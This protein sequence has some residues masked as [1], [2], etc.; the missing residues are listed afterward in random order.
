M[1]TEQI[2]VSAS[3][4]LRSHW[5]TI[6]WPQCQKN[7]Q[8]LQ[9]RIVQ[10]TK[11]ERWNKV[12]ALQHLLTRSF[13]AKSLAVKR[14]T[15]NKGKWTPGVDGQI[16]QTSTQKSQAIV[17]L[18]QRGYRPQPLRRVH[19]LKPNGKKRPLGIPT[20]KDRAMQA[21]YLMGLE[22]VAETTA[23]NHSYGFR[24]Y[25]S[26]A[27]AISQVFKTL[28][29]WGRRPEWILEGDI[30]SC[31]DA[32]SH[33]WLMDAIPIER[34]ILK[35]WLK[36]GFM[37]KQKLY[38]TK[39]GTPQGSIISPVLA[40]MALDG[41]ES[42]LYQQFGKKGTK[43]RKQSGVHLIRYAD[44]FV[45][46]GKTKEILEEQVR[47]VIETF[48]KQRGLTLSAEKTTITHIEQGFDFLGQNIRKY[49][50]KLI[51]KP[52]AK[53]IHRLLKRVKDVIGKNQ[54]ATQETVIKL[55]NPQIRGWAYYHRHVCARK[56]YEKVD[57]EIFSSL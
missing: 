28:C 6:N 3:F 49:K 22:P 19:I 37:E 54:A 56:S 2:S 8:R 30:K 34:N 39:T 21:L 51:I 52:S 4:D 17:S 47:A 27:D 55:L 42:V 15:E 40:N 10:A 9:A 11:R 48:L 35:K 45:I 12:K 26:G 14:V 7:V 50:S 33:E 1:V 23:D 57:N 13:S 20:I 29:G 41:M 5:A 32:I 31:F 38:V 46:T 36:A 43:K 24:P 18:R 25:R 44:D 53:S 16:W